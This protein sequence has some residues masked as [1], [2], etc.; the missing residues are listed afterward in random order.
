MK[1]LFKHHSL[2]L[3][4]ILVF[5]SLL[6]VLLP[7]SQATQ[8][9]KPDESVPIRVGLYYGDSTSP[10]FNLQNVSGFGSGYRFG[11]YD[12]SRNFVELGNTSQTKISIHWTRNI[13]LTES[14]AYTEETTKNGAVGCFHVQMPGEYSDFESARTAASSI[15][16]SFVSWINGKYYVRVGSY[17][18]SKEAKEAAAS[19]GGTFA[20]TSSHGIS[21]TVTGTTKILFQFDDLGNKGGLGIKP[22]IDDTVKTKTWCKG[23]QYYGSF[24]YERIDGG[25]LTLVN[26]VDTNDYIDCVISCEM[27]DYWPL[28]ALK[29]QAVSARTYYAGNLWRHNST[30][31][32]ICST[33][34]CQ[35]YSGAA[36]VGSN[37]S[38]AA[39][40][41]AGEYLWYNGELIEAFYY[42]SNGGAT[43][44]SENVWTE[45]IPYL[46]GTVDPY[47]AYIVDLIPNYNWTRTFT[48]KELQEKLISSGRTECSLITKVTLTNTAMGNVYS[49]TFHDSNGKG[50]TIYKESC[51]IFLSTPSMRFGL[52]NGPGIP[53]ETV[54]VGQ[55]SVNE[56]SVLKFSGGMSVVDGSGNIT[57]VYDIPYVI[58]G[59]GVTEPLSEVSFESTCSTSVTST[60]S[61]FVF[62]G[63][64]SGHNIGMS[65]WGANSM[66]RQGFTYKDILNFYYSGTMLG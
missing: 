49:V 50:W 66:A 2:R 24:S 44:S 52:E 34:H 28:E 57:T 36:R 48:G 27:S 39:A 65:Q 42:A 3:T 7:S 6:L 19:L 37:T 17:E 63:S 56:N 5:F 26:V 29:A 20:E 21:V 47:E 1:I 46:R 38:L 32:D 54:A 8:A 9:K 35:A 43:E 25:K 59:T 51:R 45:T 40:E 55:V 4:S 10:T 22:G 13:Y 14:G 41:T 18:K 15:E 62:K 31:F 33:V 61:T 16:D 23:N 11:Y 58:T 30:S 64:G 12:G 53:G 60:G